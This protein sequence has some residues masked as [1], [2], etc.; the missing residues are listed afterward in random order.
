MPVFESSLSERNSSLTNSCFYLLVT[1]LLAYLQKVTSDD[2]HA[3]VSRMTAAKRVYDRLISEI[4]RLVIDRLETGDDV[5]V[6]RLGS[7]LLCLSG[8][9]NMHANAHSTQKVVRFVA[10]GSAETASSKAE[11]HSAAVADDDERPAT[12][13]GKMQGL[14]TGADL[15]EDDDSPLWR[16]MCESCQLS[17]RLVHSQSS[18]RHLRFLSVVLSSNLTARL[19]TGLLTQPELLSATELSSCRDFLERMLLPLVDRFHDNEGSQYM[20]SVLTSVYSQLQPTEQV[21][22]LKEVAVRATWSVVCSDFL[23]EVVSSADPSEEVQCWLRG[24]EFGEFVVS[25]IESICCQRRQLMESR[26]DEVEDKSVKSDRSVDN[27][28]WKLLCACL[29]TNHKSGLLC[30]IYLQLLCP[31]L[32]RLIVH[33][34]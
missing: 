2:S 16:L 14:L 23:S 10:A 19:L 3:D 25:L 33:R 20:L 4:S 9:S 34:L 7:F 5:V 22:V 26:R 21:P 27:S 32:S 18:C 31:V 12:K 15:V 30:L 8:K 6:F 13:N 28:H 1:D 17:L 11:E 24:S 29:T